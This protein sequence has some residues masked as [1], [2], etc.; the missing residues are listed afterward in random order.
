MGRMGSR[1][2]PDHVVGEGTEHS[3]G[4]RFGEAVEGR[5]ASLEVFGSATLG[6]FFRLCAQGGPTCPFSKGDPPR[7]YQALAR[8]LLANPYGWIPT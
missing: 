3:L 1:R 2:T 7:R 8:R 4:A 5:D 6:E